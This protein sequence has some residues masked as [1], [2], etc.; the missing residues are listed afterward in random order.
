MGET[1][2]TCRFWVQWNTTISE[3]R[4]KAKTP[5]PSPDDSSAWWPISQA[6]DWCGEHQP[7]DDASPPT[8][9][10]AE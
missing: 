6:D 2:A 1:C 3:G 4:C 7:R 10:E 9:G 8:A 5:I